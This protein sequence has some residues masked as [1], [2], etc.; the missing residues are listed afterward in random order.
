MHIMTAA[1][2]GLIRIEQGGCGAQLKETLNLLNV[3]RKAPA[4]KLLH[5]Q[6]QKRI[7]QN[8][9]TTAIPSEMTRIKVLDQNFQ[10]KEG[11]LG[12]SPSHL[13]WAAPNLTAPTALQHTHLEQSLFVPKA[14]GMATEA[15]VTSE[16]AEFAQE[17]GWVPKAQPSMLRSLKH[18]FA[19]LLSQWFYFH[20]S[21]SSAYSTSFCLLSVK[22]YRSESNPHSK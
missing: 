17:L 8:S 12:N 3:C 9:F 1:V 5:P 11:S 7:I 4:Y 10:H 16:K 13:Y 19:L 21:S 18:S 22:Y 14:A 2:L 6:G 20:H 15:L